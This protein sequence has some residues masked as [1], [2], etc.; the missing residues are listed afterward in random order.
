MRAGENIFDDDDA[1]VHK[2]TDAQG[3]PGERDEIERHTGE[4]HQRDGEQQAEGNAERHN[5][6][7]APIPQKYQQDQD[8]QHTAHQQVLQYAAHYHI[9]VIALI[10]QWSDVQAGKFRLQHLDRRADSV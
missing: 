8:R 9:D 4:I 5:H 6:R 1:V 3:Q 10:H 2:H 7:W